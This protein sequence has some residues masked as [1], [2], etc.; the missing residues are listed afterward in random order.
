MDA[1]ESLIY[2]QYLDAYKLSKCN[3]NIISW[4]GIWYIN[5]SL[6]ENAIQIFENAKLIQPQQVKWQLMIASCHR[7]MRNY[8]T[9]INIY[10]SILTVECS[11]DIRIKCLQYLCTIMK[12]IGHHELEKYQREL[13]KQLA[14]QGRQQPMLQTQEY[15]EQQPI[16]HQQQ[17]IVVDQE[18]EEEN[19]ANVQID[20]E[21][22]PS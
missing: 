14:I 17:Q 16:Q 15:T 7:R 13:D 22:L 8:Q 4:L 18:E 19:W 2:H 20:D 9:A 10:L 3:I 6:Y 11:M 12:Q 5:N 1:D 21:L